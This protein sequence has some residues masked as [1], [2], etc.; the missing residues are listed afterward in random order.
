MYR[1][2]LVAAVIGYASAFTAPVLP[3]THA[4][5]RE[6]LLPNNLSRVGLLR[7]L[8]SRNV[9]RIHI[10]ILRRQLMPW[11][12]AAFGFAFARNVHE[13]LSFLT[14]HLDSKLES[15]QFI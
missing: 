14:N 1:A 9:L 5:G 6:F 3:S 11:Q 10:G 4:V 2:V 12:S 15:R 7:S 13:H 8:I